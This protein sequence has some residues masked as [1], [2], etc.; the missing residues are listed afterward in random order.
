MEFSDDD[1]QARLATVYELAQLRHAL[2]GMAEE[3]RV[4]LEQAERSAAAHQVAPHLIA[5]AAGVSRGR[6]TQLLSRP[7]DNDL[8]GSQLDKI[9]DKL[10]EY[11]Q[12]ALAEHKKSF[13]GEMT[14]PPYPEPRKRLARPN[15]G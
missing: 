12:D 5:M 2:S 1:Q 11:P 4:L 8:L 6:V 10:V 13:P 14:F 9:R 7:S 3:V 15:K